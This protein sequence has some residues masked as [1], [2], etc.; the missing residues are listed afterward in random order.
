VAT[1][2]SGADV[3]EFR[4]CAD[5]EN[6]PFSNQKLEGFENKIA[7]V[8]ANDLGASLR[9]IWWG[10]RRGFIRNTMNAT[11]KEG[12]CDIMIG[13]PEGYDLVRTTKPYYRSTYVFVYRK[14]KGLTLKT[15]DDPILKKIKIGVHILG[16]DY[17]NPPPVHELAK[18]GIVENVIGFDT[19]YSS[20]N[21][22][23]AIIDA[24]ASGRI[25]AAIVWGPVGYF[26]LHQQ[27]PMT[28]VPIPSKKGD[29]PFAFD[30][31]VGVKRGDDAL[32][33]RV[34]QA[35]ERKRAE[36]SGILTQYGVPRVDVAAQQPKAT[37]AAPKSDT[38]YNDVYNGW[39]WWH[40]YCYRCHG[41]NA[42]GT[43]LAPNLTDP[44][45]KMPLQEFRQIVKTG[46]ADG[47]MQAWEK[48]LDDKQIAQLYA[49][50]RARADK[51]LPVGRP[52]EVGPKGGPWV[53][54]AGWSPQR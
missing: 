11:L 13:A 27:V 23:S 30:I 4:V 41:T 1:C 50:V 51:V 31:A 26:A 46:S 40:V 18:R 39:K 28:I 42:V 7:A 54:P 45:E 43:T 32:F 44:N 35:L 9:Y 15:L 6:L 34:E 38:I 21:P 12:R 5:P 19:F 10:Q 16:E 25:D 24:V 52:D 33:D 14:D 37:A 47:Q 8:L 20:Q 49:Y 53:P 22:P 2:A 48:L 29:L 36:I 17:S 3:K